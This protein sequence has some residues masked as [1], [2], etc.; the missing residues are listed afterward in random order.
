MLE[1]GRY[2]L[3]SLTEAVSTRNEE[4]PTDLQLRFEAIMSAIG[5]GAQK[6]TLL[7][8][9]DR[10]SAQTSTALKHI[11]EE[12]TERVRKISNKLPASLCRWSLMPIGLVAEADMIRLGTDQKVAGYRLSDAG[13]TYGQPIASHILQTSVELKVDP[14]KLYGSTSKSGGNSRAVL[15]TINVL[16]SLYEYRLSQEEMGEEDFT[17]SFQQISRL[18]EID[19][20]VTSDRIKNLFAL[21]LVDCDS[22]DSEEGLFSYSWVESKN[23]SEVKPV[24]RYATLTNAIVKMAIQ[25]GTVT[26]PAVTKYILENRI[27]QANENT[28]A[29]VSSSILTNLA[30]AGF[31][32]KI[33][34]FKP[35]E[36]YSWAS[37]TD[38]GIEIIKQQ[39]LPIKNAL[40]DD[41]VGEKIRSEWKKI[42]WEKYAP[43][44]VA[45]HFELSGHGNEVSKNEWEA[46]VKE[47]LTNNNGTSRPKDLEKALGRGGISILPS[48]LASGTV[49]KVKEGKEVFYFLV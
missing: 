7:L 12:K 18:A 41:D 30:K 27:T 1:R 13:A 40:R 32:H 33:G 23:P 15:N 6:C 39:I 29:S 22:Y 11:F 4:F 31:L 19:L 14:N 25:G 34:D 8:C 26:R 28:A 24:N 20:S 45:T 35:N 49:R 36:K 17:R 44:A 43:Q 37:I 21:G 38:R 46:R 42:P 47:Y 3:K 10:N 5:N 48:L 2:S 16:E 9:L